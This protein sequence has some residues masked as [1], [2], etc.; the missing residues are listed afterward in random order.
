[1]ILSLP[2]PWQQ[3]E[4]ISPSKGILVSVL[5]RIARTKSDTEFRTAETNATYRLR[6]P[7]PEG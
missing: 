3:A 5:G 4:D 2:L 6:R 7:Y 1:M